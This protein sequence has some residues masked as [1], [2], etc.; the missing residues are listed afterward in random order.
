MV[1]NLVRN[2]NGDIPVRPVE[3]L[4][5]CVCSYLYT[6]QQGNYLIIDFYVPFCPG[7]LVIICRLYTLQLLLL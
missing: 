3:P 1:F 6:L 2:L 4:L 5:L 7:I